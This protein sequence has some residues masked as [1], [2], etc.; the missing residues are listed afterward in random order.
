MS[1]TPKLPNSEVEVKE[2]I[3]SIS[4]FGSECKN[5]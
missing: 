3:H 1:E 5:T 2:D 4:K